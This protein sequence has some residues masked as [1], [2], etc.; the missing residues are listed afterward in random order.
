MILAKIATCGKLQEK[1]VEGATIAHKLVFD[2]RIPTRRRGEWQ[3]FR[4]L[5]LAQLDGV[6]VRETIADM[7]AWQGMDI[8]F[9]GDFYQPRI[10]VYN[11]KNVFG[12]IVARLIKNFV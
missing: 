4:L 12:R 6:D 1:I 3:I 2:I 10:L 9:F 5:R 7:Q 11:L 8:L